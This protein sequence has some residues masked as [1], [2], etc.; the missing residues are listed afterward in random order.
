M[1]SAFVKCWLLAVSVLSAS[2]NLYASSLYAKS[3]VFQPTAMLDNQQLQLCNSTD[4]RVM[5][6]FNV[7]TA[8][9]Y[10]Q[11]CSIEEDT[12]N[13]PIQLSIVY[14]RDFSP[15]DFQKSAYTLLQ[16]NLSEAQFSAIEGELQRFNSNYQA[17][18]KGERYDICYSD[19]TGLLLQKN[20][21]LIS[22]SQ[23]AQL[24]QSYFQI[25]FGKRPFS[26]ALKRKLLKG[27]SKNALF[28]R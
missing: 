26:K 9:L 15:E 22:Q 19:N 23:S 17:M 12:L 25:W 11:D 14:K 28:P 27:T 16:R 10:L 4:I 7:G 21:A 20:G 18:T 3:D 1:N 8:A 24:G 13:Q 6:V 2:V 5:A